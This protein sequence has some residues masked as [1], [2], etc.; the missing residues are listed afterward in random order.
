[1]RFGIRAILVVFVGL[2]TATADA[3]FVNGGFEADAAGTTPS[4]WLGFGAR[5]HSSLVPTS[6]SDPWLPT[7]GSRFA[8]ASLLGVIGLVTTACFRRRAL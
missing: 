8:A 6:G 5:V 7:E 1:M 4:G 2:A 3:D